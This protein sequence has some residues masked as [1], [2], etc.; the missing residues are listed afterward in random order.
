MFAKEDDVLSACMLTMYTWMNTLSWFLDC[1]EVPHLLIEVALDDSRR[2]ESTSMEA[3]TCPREDLL[4]TLA[5][6]AEMMEGTE[7]GRDL[8]MNIN[9]TN[10]KINSQ[11]HT[12]LV[13]EVLCKVVDELTVKS[14]SECHQQWPW[15]R[16][17]PPQW[18]GETL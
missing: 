9:T 2:W 11:V 14:A 13:L 12:L 3:C 18:S 15:P 8:G 6:S 10:M 17:C 1:M 4:G 5:S 7:V 16:R